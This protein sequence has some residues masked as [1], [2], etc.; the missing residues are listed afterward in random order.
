MLTTFQNSKAEDVKKML[1]VRF[2]IGFYMLHVFHFRALKNV[3][4]S[5]DTPT[6]AHL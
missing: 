5:Y 1:Y 2:L 3:L 6:K 4:Y